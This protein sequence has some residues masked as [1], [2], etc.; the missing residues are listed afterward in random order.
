MRGHLDNKSL[1]LI[2]RNARTQ[3]RWNDE[4][5]PIELIHQLFDLIKMGPTS[6]NCSP[7]RYIFIVTKE[8]KERLKPSLSAGNVGKTMAA[9]VTVIIGYDMQ[10]YKHFSKLFP[11]EDAASWFTGN[12]TLILET[13]FRNGTL[14]GAYL[15][16]A[17]RSLGLDCGPMSGFDQD[18]VNNTFWPNGRIKANFLCNIG[19]GDNTNIFERSPRFNFDEVCKV[20]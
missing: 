19:V 4:P 1:D 16:I 14:Q 8:G 10:F 17:A 3:N 6:A 15:I 2:F 11:H 18:L 7:A 9:P 13:A 12:S 5:V 20:I